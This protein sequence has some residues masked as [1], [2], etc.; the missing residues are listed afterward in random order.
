MTFLQY[1]EFPDWT[2]REIRAAAGGRDGRTVDQVNSGRVEGSGFSIGAIPDGIAP[3]L[4]RLSVTSEGWL[5]LVTEFTKM[6]RRSAGT[7]TSLGD[8]AA[9]RGHARREGIANSQAVFVS[10]T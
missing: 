2:S 5:K 1:L 3:I 9:R 6:F 8:D 7:P 4:D 10:R